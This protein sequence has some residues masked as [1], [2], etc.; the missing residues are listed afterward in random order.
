M[1]K[2]VKGVEP[3]GL[4]AYRTTNP[5]GAWSNFTKRPKR[6]NDVQQQLRQDQGGLCAYCEIDLKPA[7]NTGDAD[8]RVE[9]FHPK[10]DRSTGHNW[11]L[12][13][14]NLLGCCHGGSQGNV[15]EAARRYTSPDYSCDVPKDNNDWDVV[16]LNPLNMPAYPLLFQFF[17]KDGAMSVDRRCCVAAEI[18]VAMAQST[19]DRLHLDSARLRNLRKAVLDKVND[20]LNQL[21]TS[22]YDIDAAR[23]RIAKALMKKDSHGHWPTFFSASR[24]YLGSAAET[25]LESIGYLG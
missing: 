12:D 8:F 2:I 22:G 20:E 6:R 25:Q 14:Q 16:I 4:A 15:V 19:I 21:V 3:S 17:R 23:N 24:Y 5:N 7:D 18:D 11:H 13:W 9:H 1:K 10:S